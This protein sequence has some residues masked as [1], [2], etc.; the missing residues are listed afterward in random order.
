MIVRLTCWRHNEYGVS[1]SCNWIRWEAKF[2]TLTFCIKVKLL[3]SLECLQWLTQV[4]ESL[5]YRLVQMLTPSGWKLRFR[6]GYAAGW[7]LACFPPTVTSLL[8]ANYFLLISV[9]FIVC[10]SVWHVTSSNAASAKSTCLISSEKLPTYL[11]NA[12]HDVNAV[13]SQYHQVLFLRN[14]PAVGWC[15]VQILCVKPIN[16]LAR[17]L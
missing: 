11:N 6:E 3:I 17:Y 7:S 9:Y 15:K 12:I 16:L 8:F 14:L 2:R 13:G 5:K 1:C 4:K 10:R